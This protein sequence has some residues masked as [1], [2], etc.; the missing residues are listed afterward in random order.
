MMTSTRKRVPR[1]TNV[2]SVNHPNTQMTTSKEDMVHTKI[3]ARLRADP[4]VVLRKARAFDATWTHV[5]ATK[6][7]LIPNRGSVDE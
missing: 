7:K 2:V 6:R 3:R 5:T 1:T 4:G